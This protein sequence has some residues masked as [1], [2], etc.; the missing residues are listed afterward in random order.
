MISCDFV[1]FVT[2]HRYVVSFAL[3]TLAGSLSGAISGRQLVCIFARKGY[4][5][6][7][8]R[9]FQFGDIYLFYCSA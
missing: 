8:D 5:I 9:C 3:L 7:T 6:K 4:G 1:C 2:T